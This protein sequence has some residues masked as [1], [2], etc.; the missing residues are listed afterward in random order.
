MTA[1]AYDRACD[2]AND[3]LRSL[4]TVPRREKRQRRY[5][6]NPRHHWLRQIVSTL[7]QT[8]SATLP[9]F[10]KLPSFERARL[11]RMLAKLRRFRQTA[12]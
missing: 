12:Q 1:G 6:C 3:R 7:F 2:L 8:P 10:P 5:H 11:G 9:G 4:M